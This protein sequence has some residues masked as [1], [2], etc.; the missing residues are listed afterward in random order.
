MGGDADGGTETVRW[1][2]GFNDFQFTISVM[3]ATINASMPTTIPIISPTP[4]LL[5]LEEDA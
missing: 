2:F 5:S 4:S 1:S 3:I